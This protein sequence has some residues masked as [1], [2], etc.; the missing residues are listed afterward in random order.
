MERHLPRHALPEEIQQMAP[1]EKVC[2]YCG[3]SYLILHEFKALEEQLRALKE[4]L[5]RCRGSS[6]R[7]HC[8]QE[9]LC[10]L[11]RDLEQAR[12][13]SEAQ[14]RRVRDANMQLQ[15]Q[16]DAFQGTQEELRHLR[17]ELEAER[18]SS[19]GCSRR[20]E[21]HGRL[22][23]QT[24]ALLAAARRELSAVRTLVGTGLRDS[25]VL[26]AQV[27]LLVRSGSDAAST[28]LQRLRS[29]L[30][31]A[32]TTTAALEEQL[33]GQR[34]YLEGQ[35]RELQQEAL[36]LR[37]QV[38]SLR[39]QLQQALRERDEVRDLLTAK[40]QEAEERQRQLQELKFESILADSRHSRSLREKED[41]LLTCQQIYKTLQEELAAKEKQQE[42]SEASARLAENALRLTQ[43][44][45]QQSE[46][47]VAAL[48]RERE[49][50]LVSHQRS[51][52]QLQE[53][54]RQKVLS[55]ESW[56][57]KIEAEL[58]KERARHAADFEEQSLLFKE[59][60]K[61]ELDI[62]KEKHQEI[63]RK[64]EQE[65]EELRATI[66]EL[67][68][69][70]TRELRLQVSALEG[71]LLESQARQAET[72][73]SKEQEVESLRRLVA[74][75]Q[76]RL[77]EETDSKDATA[78]A[79]REELAH[80]TQALEQLTLAQNQ[81]LQQL[82]RAR[83][84]NAVLQETV[85]REC[86]ER[87]ELTEALG[88]AKERLLEL[89]RLGAGGPPPAPQAPA[90]GDALSP[91]PPSS[92]WERGPARL[93]PV[94]GL[95]RPQRGPHSQP[96]PRPPPARGRTASV[97]ETRQRLAALLRGARLGQR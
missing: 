17:Q 80:K 25:A 38:E 55:D 21:A 14:A 85:R 74:E 20:L 39:E 61:L 76:C 51:I 65:Q 40:S 97:T 26:S 53:T 84:E 3:V 11:S 75:G 27:L 5:A 6:E 60:A 59:E 66:S 35:C 7:E 18:A 69:G 44:R 19:Q 96:L 78:Q 54:L 90:P 22:C 32:R 50:M 45:L 70:A 63:I 93:P 30:V 62:E 58:A 95:L 81:I 49:L 92:Q 71:R 2:K 86:E 4:E 12:A 64:Y 28:E 1:E 67:V 94:P 23:S 91:V 8:L 29:G 87:F 77:K 89:Q 47:E 33:Q 15:S 34:G 10:A 24:R 52:E 88:Q 82:S 68:A 42:H 36:G 56:R 9:Q 46:D 48:T 72:A 41:S 79:L 13:A 37:G 31:V 83:E 73:Q 57:E 43:T 16:C